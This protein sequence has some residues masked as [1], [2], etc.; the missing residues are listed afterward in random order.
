[1]RTPLSVFVT[2]T[3]VSACGLVGITAAPAVAVCDRALPPAAPI[4]DTPWPQLLWDYSKLPATGAGVKVAVIDSG[5]DTKHPQ[6]NGKIVGF[7]DY[8]RSSPGAEDCVGHGTAV[9]GL[10][11]GT[12][13]NSGATFRGLA[14]QAQ[15]LAARVSEKVPGNDSAPSPTEEEMAAAVRWAIANQAKVINL[16]LAYTEPDEKLP[17][18][19]K[20]IEEAIAAEIVVIAAAGNNYKK[21]NPVPSPAKWPGVVGVAA[22]DKDG[23]RLEESG[24]GS[25]VDIAAPG[26]DVIVPR[27]GGG[28][29]LDRGTSFAAP[30]VAATA[31]LIYSRYPTLSAGQVI[32]RLM[33]TADPAPG[34]RNS[35]G[36]GVG[37][38]NPLRALTEPIDGQTPVEG[39]ALPGPSLDP[40]TL[41]AQEQAAQSRYRA[42]W[43]AGIGALAAL[44]A[45]A[46]MIALPAGS[47]RRWRPAGR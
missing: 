24:M 6:L 42:W 9:A 32:K 11:V 40:K 8:L 4:S 38:V 36:W 23:Q 25:Y 47:R 31:A 35:D 41:A 29:A 43:I 30:L 21:G 14:P 44:I 17:N 1:M 7:Q 27:P 3:V 2:L 37:I 15:I 16:S 5:V 10:I 20:S 39:K 28:H 26:V 22:V 12:P 46:L 34:G 18:F 13:P 33:A 45:V 19:K